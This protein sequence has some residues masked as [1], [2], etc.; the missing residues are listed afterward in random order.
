M[1]WQHT[2]ESQSSCLL[3]SLRETLEDLSFASLTTGEHEAFCHSTHKK[4]PGSHGV[5][6]EV[7]K[8]CFDTKRVV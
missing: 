1:T 2:S 4:C 6:A 8:R 7:F 5:L 3:G